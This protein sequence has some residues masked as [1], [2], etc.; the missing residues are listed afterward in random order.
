MIGPNETMDG[1]E[2]NNSE[3][4]LRSVPPTL[5]NARRVGQPP[6]GQFRQLREKVGQPP[7]RIVECEVKD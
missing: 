1:L 5:R 4:G 2:T 3:D 7:S 6:L